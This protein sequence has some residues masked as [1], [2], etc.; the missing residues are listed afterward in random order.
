[1]EPGLS[2]FMILDNHLMSGDLSSLNFRVGIITIL[3]HRVIK[4]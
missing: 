2:S 1:M 4:I 3:P